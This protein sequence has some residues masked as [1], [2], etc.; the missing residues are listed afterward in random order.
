MTRE[1]QVIAGLRAFALPTV[2]VGLVTLL[3]TLFL[4]MIGERSDGNDET[5]RLLVVVGAAVI[6][7]LMFLILLPRTSTL[8][9][10]S[11][12]GRASEPMAKTAIGRFFFWF[13][14]ADSGVIFVLIS[15]LIGMFV[16]GIFADTLT[17][18]LLA[19]GGFF[20][21]STVFVL[22]VMLPFLKGTSQ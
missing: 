5:A 4:T 6:G 9:Q 16:T 20:V 14:I 7:V 18:I 21:F 22:F 17:N 8:R 13:G 19:V 1:D 10:K 15:A 12:M 11:V 3:G 2:A